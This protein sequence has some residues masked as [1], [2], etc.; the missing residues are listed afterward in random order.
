MPRGA[1][2]WNW[3]KMPSILTLHRRIHRKCGAASKHKCECG[4]K[5]R[6]WALMGKT[7]SDKVED[8][9]AMCRRCHLA[10]DKNWLKVDRSKH[11][12]IRDKKGRIVTT[13]VI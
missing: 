5:A 4:K 1:K 6:D 2:H 9:K 11:K 8:Y 12:I 3:S 13:L 7:Y 10:L